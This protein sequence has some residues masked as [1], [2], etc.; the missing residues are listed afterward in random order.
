MRFG[1]KILTIFTSL[2]VFLST[3]QGASIG[4]AENFPGGHGGP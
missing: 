3:L 1:Y 4:L 2:I